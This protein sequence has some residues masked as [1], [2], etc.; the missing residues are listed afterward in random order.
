MNQTEIVLAFPES[1]NYLDILQRLLERYNAQLT[2][3]KQP[4]S[5]IN[6]SVEGVV[7]EFF[8]RP[9][10]ASHL[11]HLGLTF[12]QE[13]I[14]NSYFFQ[15]EICKPIFTG[16][17]KGQLWSASLMREKNYPTMPVAESQNDMK[18]NF[19]L[20]YQA[21][22]I[23]LTYGLPIIQLVADFYQIPII[24]LYSREGLLDPG[25]KI[26]LSEMGY[27]FQQGKSIPKIGKPSLRNYF[28]K[29]YQPLI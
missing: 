2:D 17:K 14:I 7:S 1:V 11:P 27:K 15:G 6:P 20:G 18:P 16:Y 3:N 10:I 9:D 8:V 21:Q 25:V 4:I 26:T 13:G 23:D 5:W 19:W 28:S 24:H 12:I 29:I 22:Q